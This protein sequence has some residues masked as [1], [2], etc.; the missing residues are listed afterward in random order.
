MHAV[1]EHL[2]AHFFEFS[3]LHVG[4]NRCLGTSSWVLQDLRDDRGPQ[5]NWAQDRVK[6]SVLGYQIILFVIL[7]EEEDNDAYVS[8]VELGMAVIHEFV[9]PVELK[10]FDGQQFGPTIAVHL[11]VLARLHCIEESTTGQLTTGY[12]YFSEVNLQ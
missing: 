6:H 4:I 5:F 9:V 2:G 8:K 10:V 12:V 11:G 1:Q 7:L 3:I